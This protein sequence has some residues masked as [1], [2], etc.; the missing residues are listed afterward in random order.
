M[1][2]IYIYCFVFDCLLGLCCSI[3]IT[4]PYSFVRGRLYFGHCSL[5]FSLVILENHWSDRSSISVGLSEDRLFVVE[6][7]TVVLFISVI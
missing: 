4:G 2:Y 1:L 6:K 5:F 7:A 3:T